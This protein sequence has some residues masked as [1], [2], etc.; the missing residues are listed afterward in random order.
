MSEPS[1][2]EQYTIVE[3]GVE[4]KVSAQD[5][6]FSSLLDW[7]NE[8]EE[9]GLLAGKFHIL[10]QKRK[11]YLPE[12]FEEAVML[13]VDNNVE[14]NIEKIIMYYLEEYEKHIRDQS[15]HIKHNQGP[16]EKTP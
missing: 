12:M 13:Y 14:N 3:M 5:A 2:N 16:S 15:P 8:S 4:E 7:S 6:L 11:I 10:A 1:S 9:N